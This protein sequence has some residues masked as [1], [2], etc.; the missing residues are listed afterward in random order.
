MRHLLLILLIPFYS[1][2][3]VNLPLQNEL[4][5]METEDQNIRN[6]IGKLGWKNVL[7]EFLK[8]MQKIDER[9]TEKLKAIIEKHS[10]VTARLV[11]VKGV[12]AAFLVIQHSPDVVFK[13]KML[14]YLK[15]SYLN[16]EGVSGQQVAL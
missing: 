14:P 4:I 7:K 15:Q 8:K 9:N 2:A 10:W 16:D 3:E 5:E 11:G 13:E 1:F 6:Q 12:G